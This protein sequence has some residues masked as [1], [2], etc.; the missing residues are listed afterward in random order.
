LGQYHAE[1][2]ETSHGPKKDSRFYPSRKHQFILNITLLIEKNIIPN[3]YQ[4]FSKPGG[5]ECE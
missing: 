1:P 2:V 5:L 4:E 3:R